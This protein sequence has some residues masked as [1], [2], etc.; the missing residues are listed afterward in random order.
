M[1]FKKN[2][3]TH[4]SIAYYV[5]DGFLMPELILCVRWAAKQAAASEV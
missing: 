4:M 3:E 2:N 1:S 5:L